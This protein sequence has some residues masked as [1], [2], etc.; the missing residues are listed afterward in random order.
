MIQGRQGHKIEEA[1]DQPIQAKLQLV[2]LKLILTS[3]TG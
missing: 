1:Q 2:T 3:S